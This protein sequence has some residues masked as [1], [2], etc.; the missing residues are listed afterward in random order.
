LDLAHCTVPEIAQAQLADD[1]FDAVGIAPSREDPDE[2]R[3]I[4]TGATALAFRYL[5]EISTGK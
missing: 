2:N 3:F 5:R 1:P 4:G